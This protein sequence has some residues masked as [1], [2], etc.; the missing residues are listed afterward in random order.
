MIP[1][2]PTS[3]VPAALRC[4]YFKNP[5]GIDETH[6]RLSWQLQSA[7]PEIRGQRQTAY[8]VLV[9]TTPEL[10]ESGQ[11][12]YWDSGKVESDQSIHIAYAGTPLASEQ[13]CWWKVRIWDENGRVS[14][15]SETAH[16][17]MGLLQP[18]D[19]QATWIGLDSGVEANVIFDSGSWIWHP[20]GDA[21]AGLPKETRHFQR[22]ISLPTDSRL[23]LAS[24]YV[25]AS[26]G[27]VLWVNGQKAVDGVG[28]PFG[29]ETDIT[30]LLTIGENLLAIEVV[31]DPEDKPVRTAGLL[32]EVRMTFL[33]CAPLIIS[34][35][36]E[37][38]VANAPHPAW[39]AKAFTLENSVPARILGPAGIA[40]WGNVGE[41]EHRRL[42]ARM[43]RREFNLTRTLSR[44]T[45][46]V[47]GLGFFE[48]Y[49][50]GQRVGDH[51]MDPV[52][53]CYDKRAMVVTF[54]V[55]EHLTS[56]ANAI[57]VLLG[58]G[59]FFA[60]RI[61]IPTE[62]K[63]FGFPKLLF[64]MRLEYSDG[65]SETIIS[66]ENWKISD[67]GPIR[68]N[69]EFDG[70]EYDAR[71]EM[72]GWDFPGFD[73]SHWRSVE[74]VTAP[75]GKLI[76][77]MVEPMRVTEVLRPVGIEE[78]RHGMFLFDFGLN[79]YG[80]VR[81]HASGPAGTR[82][83]M[84]T[85]FSKRGDG[86]IKME[87]NRSARSTDVY[88]LRGAGRETWSP[89]FRGQGTRYVEVIGY[90]GTPTLDDLELLVVHSDLEKTGSFECS[91][92]LLNQINANVVRSTR[93]QERSVPLDP[94]RDERQAWLGHP[95]KTS[96][97]EAHVFNVA[98]FYRSFM[99]E[100]RIDQKEDGNISDAGSVW[101]FHTGDGIWPSVITILPEWFFHFYGDRRI[102]EENYETMRRWHA[103]QQKQS[104]QAD[105]TLAPG[106]YGD[107]VDAASMD[108]GTSD[109]GATSRPLMYTAYFFYN[110]RI[111]SRIA[112]QL[113]FADHATEYQALAEKVQAGFLDRF[114]D[115]SRNKF[116]SETQC[117]YVLPLAFGMIPP[118]H[119]AGVVA[120]LIDD[121]M[122]KHSG[123]LNVGLTGM[124]WFMQLLTDIGHSEVAYHVATRETRPSWGY[125]VR[126]GGTSIWE[127]WDQDT[128]DP[129]M[130]GESQLILAGNLGAWFFQTLAGIKYDLAQ[131]AFKH[132]LLHPHPVG[133]LQWVKCTFRSMHGQIG[134]DWQIVD[135][136]F[137][138]QI[139]VPAN[140]TAT[141]HVPTR[142]V[143]LVYEGSQ[144]AKLAPGVAF[145][146][147]VNGSAIFEI[148]SGRYEF[149]AVC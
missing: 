69:N 6:P 35:D 106:F 140:T 63:T 39:Q 20:D 141:V 104:L 121:I 1:T 33:D 56:G 64:Q 68:S 105:F 51:L 2:V 49:L 81:L 90:P 137:R 3:L 130:N 32:L 60:P 5:L 85:S 42:P 127:R 145:R 91:N 148:E 120:N 22:T 89:R 80:V 139:T 95:A 8:Q 4:E 117:S 12:D 41:D 47:C 75:G 126:E 44:A 57:G 59:R 78:P 97:S 28:F 45:A 13:F 72:S 142:D 131:P 34:T 125:M 86:T 11:G 55:S 26:D 113:G 66:D 144:L 73:E 29:T 70:E 37:W 99:G 15:W 31:N 129:G 135:G 103:F 123:H 19:W 10:L 122:V 46:H 9:A 96:E 111:L 107:W 143:N 61:R 128:R 27:F 110:C 82:I 102:L 112:D 116:E 67:A 14:P 134:S 98:S 133:D 115:P 83:Q 58:N 16:W 53:T 52:L 25:L 71:R 43:I 54:D 62:T 24:V 87:D 118:E 88:T 94:D 50:N 93:M 124:Q 149:H 101:P 17:S 40:P 114:F 23:L 108:E 109:S 48:L 136:E 18:S 79:H 84:R 147:N 65:S 30:R 77:Q 21:L 138:W 74:L 7:G 132:I 76:S 146:E 119:Y 38:R 100:I 36:A 92:E